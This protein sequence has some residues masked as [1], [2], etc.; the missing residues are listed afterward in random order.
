MA[1]M[2]DEQVAQARSL[3]EEGFNVSGVAFHLGCSYGTARKLIDKSGVELRPR[4]TR[5][6]PFG[7]AAAPGAEPQVEA[8][9]SF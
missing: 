9:A 2:T 3:Y 4:G 8:A 1:E 5:G 6:K 7:A